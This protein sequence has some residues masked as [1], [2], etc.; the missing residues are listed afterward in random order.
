MLLNKL[1]VCLCT[2]V[3]YRLLAA[4]RCVL[5]WCLYICCFNLCLSLFCFYSA[6][7]ERINL[8][9]SIVITGVL[10]GKVKVDIVLYSTSG[11]GL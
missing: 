10:A 11:V 1:L 6:F 8:V 2:L 3:T 4:I 7:S 5:A 9:I